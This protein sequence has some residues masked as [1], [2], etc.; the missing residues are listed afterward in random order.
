MNLLPFRDL[1]KERCGL[2]FNDHREA[3][4]R[5]GI[6][7][8]MSER[9]FS[10]EAKYLNCL[11]SEQD[12][13]NRLI[14]ILTVNETYFFRESVHLNLLTDRLMPSFISSGSAVKILSAG[15]STGEEPYSIAVALMEKYGENSHHLFSVIGFDI[16]SD[17]LERAQKSV[18][19][20]Y[21]FRSLNGLLKQKYF[22]PSGAS[23]YRI[24]KCARDK[25]MFM[26]HNLLDDSYPDEFMKAHVIFYRNVSIYFEPK[27]QKEI[28]QRLA[29]ML[30]DGG[31]LFTSS[32]ETY[33]HDMDILSLIEIDG[34]YLFRKHPSARSKG[35]K[36]QKAGHLTY[37]NPDIPRSV[38]MPVI[39][40]EG[41]ALLQM[42]SPEGS[43]D[44]ICR[45]DDAGLS[46][47]DAISLAAEKRY[48]EAL[49][50]LDML[51]KENPGLISACILKA[52]I[53]VNLRM[54]E[55][56][57][58]ICLDIISKD[59]WC[60]EGHL[61]LGLIARMKKDDEVAIRKFREAIYIQSSCWLAHFYLAEI[62][63]L[64]GE[65]ELARREYEVVTRILDS[66]SFN[67][68][69]LSYFLLSVSP[70]QIKHLCKHNISKLKGRVLHGI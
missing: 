45:K 33:S 40:Q 43:R 13:F 49:E 41:D 39:K 38:N 36:P 64:R 46:L 8:R 2:C 1:I 20:S 31:Y 60:L 17:A 53:F 52:N 44:I 30:D 66:G 68:H 48:D 47:N 25:V 23:H 51:L 21:S 37:K 11:L 5:E 70:D 24:K 63:S 58:R 9:G 54:P 18:F 55:E 32:T 16:D 6:L 65:T 67:G 29:G 62:Y 50:S 12:E 19:S 3:A 28:L 15:C 27:I 34:V 10:S 57:E 69:G 14:N 4:L 22:E 59:R 35:H 56:A 61:L 26:K 42:P 7:S